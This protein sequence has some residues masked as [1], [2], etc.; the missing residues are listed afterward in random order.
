MFRF[1][2]YEQPAFMG[3]RTRASRL[4]TTLIRVK[5]RLCHLF[6]KGAT[7]AKRLLTL[8]QLAIYLDV[9]CESLLK[10]IEQE[11]NAEFPGF[12]IN[13]E[14]LVPLDEV[15]DWLLRLLNC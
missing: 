2:F 7:M 5:R 6:E 12:R 9:S 3:G 10:L 1:G 11:D 8:E 14:W 13:G 15:P 4:A